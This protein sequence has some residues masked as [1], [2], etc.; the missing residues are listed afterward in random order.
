MAAVAIGFVAIAGLIAGA[1]LAATTEEPTAETVVKSYLGALSRRDCSGAVSKLSEAAQAQIDLVYS[2]VNEMCKR[3]EESRR[4]PRSF[5]VISATADGSGQ[6]TE[7]IVEVSYADS[8]VTETYLV[9][10]E[11]GDLKVQPPWA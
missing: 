1:L 8:T 7:V 9:L 11:E 2:D 5:K 4:I 6:A 10:E 3:L